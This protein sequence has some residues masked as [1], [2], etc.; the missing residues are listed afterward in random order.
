M[1]GKCPDEEGGARGCRSRQWLL[2]PDPTLPPTWI[3]PTVLVPGSGLAAVLRTL[4]MFHD[5]E[6]ARACGLPE[7]TL[8]L[9]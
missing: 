8:V 3:L 6:H 5:E 7:N 2:A 4:P 9:P 1:L